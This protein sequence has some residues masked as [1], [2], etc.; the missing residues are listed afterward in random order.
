MTTQ[1]LDGCRLEVV[2]EIVTQL[3]DM[4]RRCHFILSTD[5]GQIGRSKHTMK[6][7]CRMF[8]CIIPRH[9]KRDENG[10]LKWYIDRVVDDCYKV[11][12]KELTLAVELA[13]KEG[14]FFVY[15]G[16][17]PEGKRETVYWIYNQN[18][19]LDDYEHGGLKIE[20]VYSIR[21][22]D[23]PDDWP[24]TIPVRNVEECREDRVK[25]ICEAFNHGRRFYPGPKYKYAGG[26]YQ[27]HAYV[28]TKRH[29]FTDAGADSSDCK[30]IRRCEVERAIELML[31][32][33]LYLYG[34]EECGGD[35]PAYFFDDSPDPCRERMTRIED[36]DWGGVFLI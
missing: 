2:R 13:A 11:S 27:E 14:D 36:K 3:K 9:E 17:D 29:A 8:E 23:F 33:G 26:P 18:E 16:H 30:D 15:R 35:R 22:D 20:R 4:R 34:A 12:R 21:Q 6:L 31:A 7:F 25:A 10:R 28:N 5:S 24:E 19:E 32:D 1:V